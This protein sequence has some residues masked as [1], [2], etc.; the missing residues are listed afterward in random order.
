MTGKGI[1][2]LILLMCSSYSAV[3]DNSSPLNYDLTNGKTIIIGKV[4]EEKDGKRYFVTRKKWTL[5]PDKI[6]LHDQVTDRLAF[7]KRGKLGE[8]NIYASVNETNSNGILKNGMSEVVPATYEKAQMAIEKLALRN[9]FIGEINPSWEF[10]ESDGEC[11]K[12]NNRCGN[13]IAV[14]K[15]YQKNYLDF[16]KSKKIKFE[17]SQ[18][19][20]TRTESKDVPKCIENYCSVITILSSK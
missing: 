7:V 2:L 15:K 11:I 1:S 17:C 4:I 12:I 20:K 6:R 19:Q 16:L 8:T 13:P 18:M 9:D 14:N 3:A 10:C 5:G